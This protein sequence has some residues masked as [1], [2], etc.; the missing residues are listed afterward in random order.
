[1][2]LEYRQ[3]LLVMSEG[4]T[5]LESNL[6]KEDSPQLFRIFSDILHAFEQLNSCHEQMADLF[7][8]EKKMDELLEDCKDV[9]NK[10]PEWFERN[11]N[12]EKQQLLSTEIIPSFEGWKKQ[13]EIFL[14]P[15][16]SH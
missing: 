2:L 3:L 1:M 11:T 4:F 6:N 16:L 13:M 10:L 5:Y 15:Y 8:D 12:E 14:A 9:I 7:T